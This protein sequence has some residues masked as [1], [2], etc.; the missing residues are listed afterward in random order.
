M[1]GN[2]KFDAVWKKWGFFV[3]SIRVFESKASNFGKSLGF[4]QFENL[5]LFNVSLENY[6]SE[7]MKSKI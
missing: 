7:E 5:S 1:K 3:L 4:R 2:R 6:G